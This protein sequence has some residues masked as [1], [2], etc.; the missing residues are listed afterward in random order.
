[1]IKIGDETIKLPT[2][3]FKPITGDG[4]VTIAFSKAMKFP[5]EW[6]TILE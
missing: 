1:M 4:I 6:E 5:K 3:K 2:M